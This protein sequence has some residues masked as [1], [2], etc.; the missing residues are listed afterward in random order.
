MSR[1]TAGERAQIPT[2]QFAEPEKRG[3]PIDTRKRAR[4]AL[5]LVGMHGSP[6]EKARVDGAVHAKYPTIGENSK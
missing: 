3:Y 4:T 1:L 6:A 2:S 5:G